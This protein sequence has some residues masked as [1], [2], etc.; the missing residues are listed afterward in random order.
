MLACARISER[1]K[2]KLQRE[3]NLGSVGETIRPAP[4][5]FMFLCFAVQI[6]LIRFGVVQLEP[7]VRSL[8]TYSKGH[9]PLN[10]Q[11]QT[12]SPS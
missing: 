8:K 9:L 10:T 5:H 6:F 1:E 3:R 7:Q 2:D 4:L 12:F 11:V